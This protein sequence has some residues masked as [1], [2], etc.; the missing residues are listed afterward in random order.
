MVV[1]LFVSSKVDHAWLIFFFHFGLPV[2]EVVLQYHF[3]RF[4]NILPNFLH[5]NSDMRCESDR[6]SLSAKCFEKDHTKLAHARQHF[7]ESWS[8]TL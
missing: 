5:W 1:R 4:C 2:N 6:Q 8:Q 3:T 7:L